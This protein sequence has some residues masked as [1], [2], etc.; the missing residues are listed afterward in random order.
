MSLPSPAPDPFLAAEAVRVVAAR[1]VGG[2]VRLPGSKSIT[3]R[4]LLMAGLAE[5]P[6][7]IRNPLECDDSRYMIQA[8]VQ[9]GVDVRRN[10]SDASVWVNGVGGPFPVKQCELKLGNAGTAL[11]F[12][13]GALAAGGGNY[14]V[15]GDPRMRQRPIADLVKAIITLGGDIAAPTGC[16]PVTIGPRPI[17]G[18][19]V[20]ILGSTSSQFISSILMAAPLASRRV[21]MR[22]TGELVSRPYI[23][24]T[25]QGMRD[26]GAKVFVDDKRH[27]GE[28]L[29]EVVPGRPYKGRDFMVEGDASA[30]SYFYAAAAVTG[31]TIRVEGVGKETHQGDSRCADV[32]A[33]MGCRVK[34]ELDAIT[35]SGGLLKKVDW[36]CADIPDVVPTLAVVALFAHGRTRLRGVAH[37]RHKESD[38]IASVAAELRKIG[39]QVKELADGLEI[40][41]TLGSGPTTL[42]DAV[43]DTWG[44]H[45]I[46]MA[47]SV[48]ALGVSGVTI[49]NPHVVSKSF[50]TFFEVLQSIGARV[51]VLGQAG[52]KGTS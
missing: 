16:P 35:V 22:V 5:G 31:G 3:N 9:L 13:T 15:D 10:E 36:N 1:P 12:L 28:P 45:R 11:R 47:L 30:A 39:G 19:R 26:F 8:L 18:G 41:G 20:D 44:D 43:I 14:T 17:V 33:A 50:P 48:A 37:L 40:E 52:S 38:R 24:L 29:F 7:T 46:A 42:H 32:L 2:T 21:E 6:S 51:E 25:L 27:D 34:K 4:A 49:R 23:D